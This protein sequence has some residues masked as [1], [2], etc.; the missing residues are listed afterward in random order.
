MKKWICSLVL[1][2]LLLSAGGM[3]A[4]AAEAEPFYDEAD[5][6]IYEE[7]KLPQEQEPDLEPQ[8]EPEQPAAPAASCGD[9]LQWSLQNGTLTVSG[10]G[11]MYDFPEDSA[12]WASHREEIQSVILESGVSAVGAGAFRD[13]DS[14][15]SVSFGSGMATLGSGCFADCDGL[16]EL[17]FPEGFRI[18]GEECL[19]NCPNLKT[20]NFTGGMP[21]FKLNCLWATQ[22]TVVYPA[23]RPW[24][25]NHVQQLGEAF[26]GRIQFRL[27]DGTDPLGGGETPEQT[28][29]E[30]VPAEPAPTLE[31][32]LPV[33]EPSTVP[34]PAETV[35]AETA[36]AEET[37]LPESV[38]ETTEAY[39]VLPEPQNQNAP[40]RVTVLA[41]L[42][43]L[44]VASGS[45]IVF[46]LI[47]LTRNSRKD[48]TGDV[49]EIRLEDERKPAR[50]R[51]TQAQKAAGKSRSSRKK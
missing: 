28:L 20:L 37:I 7:G 11:P 26:Q 17:S 44:V 35:P 9:N 12:P 34:A 47:H 33:T 14:L 40:L 43:V 1:L 22:A 49:S 13:Y 48:F 51:P 19:Y 21:S 32:T 27:S 45:G 25:I 39:V 24:P 6:L 18:L 46:L 2:S 3:T 16:T 10:F 41:A 23:E 4:S 50:R 15:S 29:P 38:P 42:I 36:G 30:T 5:D 31:Q 8:E